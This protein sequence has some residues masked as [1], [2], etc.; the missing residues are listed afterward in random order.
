MCAAGQPASYVPLVGLTALQNYIEGTPGAPGLLGSLEILETAYNLYWRRDTSNAD[1]TAQLQSSIDHDTSRIALLDR[2]RS[3][4]LTKKDLTFQEFQVLRGQRTQ[5]YVDLNNAGEAF[6][7]AVVK[8]LAAHPTFLEVLGT[9]ITV[10]IDVASE[11]T[12]GISV[13][14]TLS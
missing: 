12:L 11:A 2:G 13:A 9:M 4:I 6:K 5:L 7:A 10:G 8:D 14:G 1:K 3:D